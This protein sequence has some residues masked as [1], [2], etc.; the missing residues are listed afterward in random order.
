MSSNRAALFF[1]LRNNRYIAIPRNVSAPKGTVTTIAIFVPVGNPAA[2]GFEA[3]G[4]GVRLLCDAPPELELE[5]L[6][7]MVV[8]AVDAD[9]VA[10]LRAACCVSLVVTRSDMRLMMFLSVACHMTW[11]TS[12]TMN[13]LLLCGLTVV[14]GAPPVIVSLP[15]RD[16]E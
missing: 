7:V 1:R 10:P 13:A 5:V 8:S 3:V 11:I 12:A 9:D 15:A 14:R 2:L 6:E 16:V 4:V